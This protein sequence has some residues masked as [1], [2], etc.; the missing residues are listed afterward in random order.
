[1][2]GSA[3]LHTDSELLQAV[4]GATIST[5]GTPARKVAELGGGRAGHLCCG[6][7]EES[8]RGTAVV[9]LLVTTV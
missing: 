9:L 5:L 8:A 3:T 2:A 6:G 1:M 7:R 4:G